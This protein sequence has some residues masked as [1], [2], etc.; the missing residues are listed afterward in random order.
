M[1]CIDKVRLRG[2]A[3]E[4]ILHDCNTLDA[5]GNGVELADNEKGGKM[6]RITLKDNSIHF[7]NLKVAADFSLNDYRYI[8]CDWKH[9][10]MMAESSLP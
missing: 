6:I 1:I 2:K 7:I 4:K 9:Y 10:T 8:G 3:G 5:W